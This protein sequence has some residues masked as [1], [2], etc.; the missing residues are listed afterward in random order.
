M[1]FSEGEGTSYITGSGQTKATSR[2]VEIYEKEGGVVKRSRKRS[3]A[4]IDL[5]ESHLT[6][7]PI[8]K[9]GNNDNCSNFASSSNAL[10]P[11]Q[12][13]VDVQNP[14][15]K[16]Q[17]QDNSD[18]TVDLLLGDDIGH[19]NGREIVDS[20]FVDS[21]LEFGRQLSFD[22]D[23]CEGVYDMDVL[24][25]ESSDDD[26]LADIMSAVAHEP[27]IIEHASFPRPKPLGKSESSF[28]QM[29]R[30]VTARQ[31]PAG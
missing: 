31:I 9:S 18:N 13:L 30:L 12:Q 3:A 15:P 21:N 26:D 22:L 28:T 2:R 8:T 6:T 1:A 10:T 17:K 29:A 7:S 27:V 11:Q 5:D 25:S 16:K 20:N 14:P 23:G 4:D 19:C 24:S